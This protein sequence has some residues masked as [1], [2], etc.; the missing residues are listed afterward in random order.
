MGW[1]EHLSRWIENYLSNRTQATAF[2]DALSTPQTI[3]CGVPQGSIL[4]PLLFILYINDLSLVA[5]YCTTSLYAN[6]T[7]ILIANYDMEALK[8]RLQCDLWQIEN[9]LDLNKL[10]VNTK[11]TK[12]MMFG[13]PQRITNTQPMTLYMKNDL[14]EKVHTYTYLGL[15]LDST[16][17]YSAHIESLAKKVS[18]RLGLLGRIHKYI[19]MDTALT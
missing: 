14:L 1:G 15:M 19:S 12:Y 10:T 3:R 11:K 2:G 8:H 9:W 5:D 6:D 13:T 17:N 16:L 18:K 4:G 7:A